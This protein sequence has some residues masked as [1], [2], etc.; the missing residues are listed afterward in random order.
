MTLYI[1][2]VSYHYDTIRCDIVTPH[3]A[4]RRYVIR[5]DTGYKGPSIKYVT[6]QVGGGL[7][8]C[9]SL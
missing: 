4:M 3:A 9:D 5:Y 8:K 6:L 7:R 2:I 1:K